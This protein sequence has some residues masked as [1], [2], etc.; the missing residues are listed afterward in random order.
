MVPH[1]SL[2]SNTVYNRG[3][4]PP[5]FVLVR[6]YKSIHSEVT[7]CCTCQRTKQSTTKNGKFPGNIGNKKMWIKIYLYLIGLYEY[8]EKENIR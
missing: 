6:P 3:S 7:G 2:P 5:A 8:I 1:V 4:D